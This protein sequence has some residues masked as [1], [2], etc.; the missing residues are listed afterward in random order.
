MASSWI[1]NIKVWVFAVARMWVGELS[2][3]L[4][5][6]SVLF[7]EVYMIKLSKETWK[8][9]FSKKGRNNVISF[10]PLYMFT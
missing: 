8:N 6:S 4:S 7:L 5:D 10:M 9:A 2:Q 1:S 3:F